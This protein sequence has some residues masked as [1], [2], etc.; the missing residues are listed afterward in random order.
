MDSGYGIY[1]SRRGDTLIA[2]AVTFTM[3]KDFGVIRVGAVRSDGE[4]VYHVR[5]TGVGFAAEYAGKV[6]GIFQR[7]HSESEFEGAG[8]GLA[9]VERIIVRHGGR[10]WAEGKTGEGAAFYF[11]LPRNEDL[12]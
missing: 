1:S 6:F 4:N 8:V 2:N 5:D 9:I 7:L 12:T 10:A 3:P 11:T